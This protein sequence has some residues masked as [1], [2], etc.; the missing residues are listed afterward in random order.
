MIFVTVGNENSMEQSYL[1]HFNILA[2]DFPI[3]RIHD[4]SDPTVVVQNYSLE[5]D[6]EISFENIYKLAA[7]YLEGK[8]IAKDDERDT[9]INK[10]SE[11]P[12]EDDNNLNSP[13]FFKDY[14]V[15]LTSSNFKEHVLQSL[16]NVLLLVYDKNNKSAAS[17][18]ALDAFES[19]TF[20]INEALS[21]SFYKIDISTAENKSLQ[22]S[23][24]KKVPNVRFYDQHNK[25]NVTDYNQ[26][27]YSYDSIKAFLIHQLGR[28]VDD[29]QFPENE[30]MKQYA[31]SLDKAKKPKKEENTSK[32]DL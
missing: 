28:N 17:S 23:V 10:S 31:D 9:N 24:G 4:T 8:L 16:K 11:Q 21:L 1:E 13:E 19:L 7:D 30:Y 18:K 14:S 3:V 26:E 5:K 32:I 15:S 12:N 25:Q 27:D 2:S 22:D 6:K 29:L 20:N